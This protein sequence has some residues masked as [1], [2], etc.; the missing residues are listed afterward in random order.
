MN[1][2]KVSRRGPFADYSYWSSEIRSREYQYRED[3]GDEH[4]HP[5]M[6][7]HLRYLPSTFE[8]EYLEDSGDEYSFLDESAQ[9]IFLNRYE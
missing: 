6:T 4:I 8:C 2:W 1:M 9:Q 5:D 7:T 3:T